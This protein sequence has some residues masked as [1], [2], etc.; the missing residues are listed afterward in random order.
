VRL[1]PTHEAMAQISRPFQIGLVVVVRLACAWL[2]ALHG[3]SSSP[4]TSAS[5]STPVVTSSV[6]PSTSGGSSSVNQAGREAAHAAA[7][8][9]VYHGAAP[10]VEGLTR[11]VAKAHEAVAISQQDANNLTD[12]SRE[13]SGES[14]SSQPTPSAS[15]QASPATRSTSPTSSTATRTKAPTTTSATHTRASTTTTGATATKHASLPTHASALTAPAGQRAVEA[16]LKAGKI[17]VLL[18]WN[19]AGSDDV[20]VHRELQLLLKLHRIA[21]KAKAEEFR[22]AEKFFGLELDQRI[23]VHEALASQ[24]AEYGS[25]TRAVQV[26][27]TPTI[28][29]IN[30][31]GQAITLTGITDAYSIEQAIEEARAASS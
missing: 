3:H 9:H 1:L 6:S 26:Y 29:V 31:K 16:E 28:L 13:A 21:S 27:T 11:A 15:T 20:V 2:F 24:V 8:T 7:P 18:F 17:V 14:S 30:P 12:K 25:I 4:T 19:P 10:G 23:A 5:S 22:H